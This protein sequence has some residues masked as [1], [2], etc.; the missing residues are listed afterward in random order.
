[1]PV[2]VIELASED[3]EHGHAMLNQ[4]YAPERPMRFPAD[5]RSFGLRLRS[6]QAGDVGAD[7][8]DVASPTTVRT[9]SFDELTVVT[10]LGGAVGYEHGRDHTQAGTGDVVLYPLAH[11]M[12]ATWDAVT[13]EVLRI[14][15]GPVMRAA[16]ARAGIEAERVQ[17]HGL[18][19]LSPDAASRWRDLSTYVHQMMRAP[20]SLLDSAL[21][22]AELTGVIAATAL[23]VFPNTTI[24]SAYMPG[25][26]WVGPTSLRRAVAHLHAYADRPLTLTGLAAVAGT[27]PRALQSAFRRYYDI[28]A[29]EYLRRVRLEGAYRDL[30][31]TDPASGVS[32]AQVA[33][34]WGFISTSWFN[35]DYGRRFGTP[36]SRTLDS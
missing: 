6:M 9:T 4:L 7:W 30:L 22:R 14:P 1:V 8:L 3:A 35:K 13:V 26:G 10:V 16:R 28:T 20:G 25:E 18:A 2:E 36:P 34:R 12:D 15:M 5:D 21:V 23:T 32:V 29:A 24:T 27:S 17:F 31:D 33:A 19:P 11:G